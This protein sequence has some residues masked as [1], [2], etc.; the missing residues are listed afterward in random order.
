MR[1]FCPWNS[2]GKNTG[3]GCHALLQRIFPTQRLSPHFLCLLLFQAGSL[4]LYHLGSLD[5]RR[6]IT[7]FW[8]Q[9]KNTNFTAHCWLNDLEKDVS[10]SLPKNI[11][12]TKRRPIIVPGDGDSVMNKTDLHFHT[13]VYCKFPLAEV[14]NDLLATNY[15]R[16]WLEA[17]RLP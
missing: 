12:W 5:Q 10:C 17:T 13:S 15:I 7:K 6:G 9:Q 4:P 2:P 14:V 16:S 8:V 11:Y 1:V 3:V